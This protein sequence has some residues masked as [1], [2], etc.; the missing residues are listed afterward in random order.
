MKKLLLLTL[1]AIN[2]IFL[3]GCNHL[4]A[5]DMEMI[6]LDR[7]NQDEFSHVRPDVTLIFAEVNPVDTIVGQL[8]L[9]FANK[10]AYLSQGTIRINVQA[11]GVLGSEG[12]V[13][14]SMLGGGG[15]IDMARI[16]A[17]ALTPFGGEKSS[18]LSVPYAFGSRD[19]FWNFVDSDLAQ[20]FLM[21]P[22]YNGSGVRGLFYGEEGFRHFFTV[23]PITSMEDLSGMRLRVS[24]DP[25]MVGMVENLGAQ[26]TAISFG[27]LYSALAT[28]VVDGAEQPIVNY[29][30]NAFPEVAPYL[31]LNGHTLG[32][33]QVIVSDEAWERL[34]TDQQQILIEAGKYASARNREMSELMEQEVLELLREEG[35]TVIDVDD[36]AP[37]REAVMPTIKS[38]TDHM[39]DLF[40]QI[41]ELE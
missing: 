23:N 4:H 32:A 3:T 21:E 41:L 33:V 14:N 26:A 40:N 1:F 29:R 9:T 12:D 31:I 19:H 8:S 28:G 24:T 25:M 35:V 34:T 7:L 37:W 15:V 13:L 18:L 38:A 36:I 6:D 2:A 30:S 10:V 16:S 20:S 5:P 27:E 11:S 39:W 22:H 17:F